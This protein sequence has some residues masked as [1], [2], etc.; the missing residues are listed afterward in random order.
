M[1]EPPD[2]R[3]EEGEHPDVLDLAALL[4]RAGNDPDVALP[5]LL[6]TTAERTSVGPPPVATMLRNDRVRR[7]SRLLVAAAVVV[8]G[9]GVGLAT[10]S[11]FDPVPGAPP[12]AT[13]ALEGVDRRSGEATRQSTEEQAADSAGVEDYDASLEH[14]W[15]ADLTG[16]APL[17]AATAGESEALVPTSADMA[18]EG[19]GGSA[20]T[21]VDGTWAFVATAPREYS[22]GDGN[23]SFE[24]G[25]SATTAPVSATVHLGQGGDVVVWTGC[26]LASGTWERNGA[27][28]AITLRDTVVPLCETPG[29]ADADGE[30]QRGLLERLGLGAVRYLVDGGGTRT[31]LDEDG[32]VLGVLRRQ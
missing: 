29:A 16:G 8:A 26:A 1:T 15:N 14:P 5:D 19:M 32:H 28:A 18:V 3:P 6:A 24:E 13:V 17:A 31:L 11:P 12:D 30:D 2:H 10:A 23:V 25:L 21:R 9:A 7:R 27:G 20:V 4:R 22:V